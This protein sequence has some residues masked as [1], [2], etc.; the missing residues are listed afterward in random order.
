MFGRYRSTD[1]QERRQR[2]LAAHGR[3]YF[4]ALSDRSEQ[5]THGQLCE[6]H[7]NEVHFPKALNYPD[8]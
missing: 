5:A 7:F 8:Y 3:C 1:R 4:C 6:R 2:K